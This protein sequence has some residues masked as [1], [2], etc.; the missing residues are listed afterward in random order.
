MKEEKNYV[1]KKKE[2]IITII[3]SII[4]IITLGFVVYSLV[5]REKTCN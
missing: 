2:K 5:K 4:I 3:T 1:R